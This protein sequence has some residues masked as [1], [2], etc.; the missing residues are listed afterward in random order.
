[1]A[2]TLS[3]KLH[4]Q[5][6]KLFHK[7]KYQAALQKLLEALQGAQG[8]AR[9]AAEIYNDIGVT[10]KQLEDYPAAHKA[11]DEALNR[12]SQL[13]DQKGQAQTFGNRAAVHEA[14]DQFDQAVEYYKKSAKMLEAVGE[15]EMAMYA[16]QAVSRLR[17]KQRQYIA[18]IGAYEEGIDNMP[19]GSLKRK[20][21]QNIIKMPGSMIGG[22]GSGVGSSQDEDP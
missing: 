20:I 16:W 6:L 21:L 13:Q 2:N 15:S 17:L 3:K 12:F 7:G 10:Y 4:K 18:A 22:L 14:E 9:Q 5:G 8:D 1:M 11:L 19:A